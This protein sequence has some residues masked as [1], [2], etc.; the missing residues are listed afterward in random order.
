MNR[1]STGLATLLVAAATAGCGTVTASQP[2]AGGPTTAGHTG[3]A[4]A[5]AS[6]GSASARPAATGTLAGCQGAAPGGQL[7]VIT[8]AGN[9][10]TYCMRVGQEVEVQLRGTISSPWL[11]PLAS[12]S[13]LKPVPNGELSLIAGLTEGRFAAAQAGQALI[14]SIRPP[15]KGAIGYSK[16]E[17]QPAFPLPRTYPLRSCAP[18]GRFSVTLVVVG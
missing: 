11:A 12:S 10:K 6:R 14:T 3:Q 16:N 9:G 8:M 13:V 15:C 7:L 1:I 17:L 18:D 4:P 5:A 2:V